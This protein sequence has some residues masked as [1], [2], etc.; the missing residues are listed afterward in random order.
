M[1]GKGS[2]REGK[3]LQAIN[4]RLLSSSVYPTPIN[5]V[6]DI[7][8]CRRKKGRFFPK[9]RYRPEVVMIFLREVNS[10]DLWGMRVVVVKSRRFVIGVY[11]RKLE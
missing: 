4:V 1:H 6:L 10:N 3:I 2:P 8:G 9:V 11:F 5:P 7:T